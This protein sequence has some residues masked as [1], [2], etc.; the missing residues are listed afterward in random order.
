MT[1][2]GDARFLGVARRTCTRAGD[3]RRRGRGR[4]APRRR[5]ER[6]RDMA[7]AARDPRSDRSARPSV[8][9]HVIPS[10]YVTGRTRDGHHFRVLRVCGVAVDARPVARMSTAAHGR[11][12]GAHGRVAL[13]ASEGRR[14]RSCA[15]SRRRRDRFVWRVAAPARGVGRDLGRRKGRDPGVAARARD[16]SARPRRSTRGSRVRVGSRCRVRV[17]VR[18]VR[19]VASEAARVSQARALRGMARGARAR[20]GLRREVR[21][22]ARRTLVVRLRGFFCVASVACRRRGQCLLMRRVAGGAHGRRARCPRGGPGLR[23]DRQ[24]C[25]GFPREH[26][27][28]KSAVG[29]R[30]D[31]ALHA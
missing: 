24:A 12:R 15:I 31:V 17:R 11:V 2:P 18:V 13:H 26:A 29:G 3:G 10:L 23:Y 14:V 5:G 22:V 20:V 19:R 8:K 6:M 30:H 28:V 16:R 4:R 25:V 27:S 7:L 21:A 9:S 1:L